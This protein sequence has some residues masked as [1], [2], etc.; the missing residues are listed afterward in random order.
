MARSFTLGNLSD[1][2]GLTL[3][4]V[5]C[6]AYRLDTHTEVETQFTDINGD[7]TFSALPDSVDC[8]IFV[9]H[10]QKADRYYSE[11]N[12]G[13]GEAAAD[14]NGHTTTIDGGKITT[15]T[16]ETDRLIADFIE[17]GGGATD[18]NDHTTKISGTKIVTSSIEANKMKT[19]SLTVATITL[20][21][22]GKFVTGASGTNRI[23]ITS[24]TIAGINSS[25]VT[26]FEIKAS[27]GKAYFG[28]GSCVLD[29]T[30]GITIKGGKLR[31]QDSSGA[32]SG[33]LYIDT[34]GYM[35]AEA[36]SWLK[37]SSAVS[38]GSL[39][40]ESNGDGNVG[41]TSNRWASG[42]FNHLNVYTRMALPLKSTGGDPT[43][44][45][46]GQLY[47][48]TYDDKVRCFADS[49]WRDLATW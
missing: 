43:G 36:W 32:H 9:Y 25:N 49:A 2:K 4:N 10:H 12:V 14:V 34:D 26:Q 23:E 37:I 40:P 18:I 31:L 15:N 13:V 38:T 35:R 44:A 20:A 7:A 46:E 22:S 19:S 30:D 45:I 5:R 3:S 17:V 33:N 41:T 42:H 11:A 48:N 29:A 21:D 28:A 39:I 47:V 8:I 6:V 1:D 16:I 27:D 24:S